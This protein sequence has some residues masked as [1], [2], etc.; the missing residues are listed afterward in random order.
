MEESPS[1]RTST[2]GGA[3]HLR[4]IGVAVKA[5]F[6]ASVALAAVLALV[7]CGSA[8][9]HGPEGVRRPGRRGVGADDGHLGVVVLARGSCQPRRRRVEPHGV[10][11][12]ATAFGLSLFLSLDMLPA[13]YFAP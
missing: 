8:R 12:D 2:R 1:R 11:V 10:V 5:L 7:S 13:L 4:A 6:W 3:S 9:D